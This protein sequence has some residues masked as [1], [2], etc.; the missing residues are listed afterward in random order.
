MVVVTSDFQE[1]RVRYLFK[2]IFG[3][4]YEINYVF[5][6]SF[7][8][9]KNKKEVFGRQKELLLKIKNIMSKM[10]DGNHDFLKN[11]LYKIKFYKEQ[12][13]EWVKNFVSKGET[14]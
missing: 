1:G 13:P 3:N 5:T 4:K 11:K 7:L 10:K 6:P 9:S 8:S 2:K 12:R 14:R